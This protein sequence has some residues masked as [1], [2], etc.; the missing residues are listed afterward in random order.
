MPAEGIKLKPRDEIL[1]FDEIETL[2]RVFVDLGIRKIRLTGGEPLVRHGV[3]QLCER[4]AGIHGLDTLALSTNGTY[5]ADK[6]RALKAAGVQ[7]LNISLDT[8][9]AE[10][11]RYITF[12]D[13]FSGT[14]RGIEAALEAGFPSLKINTVV[15]RGFNDDE[16]LDFVDFAIAL[17]LNVRFIEYMPFL[18]NR[19]READCVPCREMQERIERK[20]RLMP[21][22]TTIRLAGPAAEFRVDGTDAII[23]FIPTMS[24]PFCGGCNRLRLTADGKL[25]TCLFA[26][27]GFDLKSMLRTG[28]RRVDRE[29]VEYAIQSAV[30]M[31]WKQHPESDEL[32][33]NQT[34][35]MVAIGG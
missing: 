31:K 15:M 6:A 26:S 2:A 13:S 11:F 25:R 24:E 18:G 32:T 8:L 35:A 22:E 9:Q 17:S 4:L 30:M 27:D 23:G 20:Y 7:T 14:L 33:A 3:E 19:W 5:L 1:S 12:R 21:T 34:R 28:L 29:T 10:R 16:L